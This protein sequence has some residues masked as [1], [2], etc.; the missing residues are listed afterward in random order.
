MEIDGERAA[1]AIYDRVRS[2][3]TF[4]NLDKNV[5]IVMS[6]QSAQQLKK[7][8]SLLSAPKP[9]S[10]PAYADSYRKLVELL[11]EIVAT[12][13]IAAGL[14]EFILLSDVQVK[15]FEKLG[16]ETGADEDRL[17]GVIDSFV[18]A[19][20]EP[21]TDPEEDVTIAAQAIVEA[22]ARRVPN[23]DHYSYA[24]MAQH[25]AQAVA[26]LDMERLRHIRT[27]L[28][29]VWSQTHQ[30]VD[31]DNRALGQHDWVLAQIEKL[32]EQIDRQRRMAGIDREQATLLLEVERADI[33]C[34]FL[35]T[36]ELAELLGWSLERT[37]CVAEVLR[38]AGILDCFRG[39]RDR[40]AIISRATYYGEK[41]VTDLLA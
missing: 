10:P 38:L 37:N 4:V 36:T 40:R 3:Q 13:P 31:G 27:L 18:A 30:T 5:V 22:S 26:T 11:I 20:L 7:L 15:L 39:A 16:N 41:L 29:W 8:E 14:P 23:T 33:R 25:A 2:Q 24:Q 32:T 17:H 34:I 1:R 6:K 28:L 21:W 12:N 19:V 9:Q 35:C